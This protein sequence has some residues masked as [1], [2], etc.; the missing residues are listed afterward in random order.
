MTAVLTPLRPAAHELTRLPRGSSAAGLSGHPDFGLAD[1]G[2]LDGALLAQ[3]PVPLGQ[4]LPTA[5]PAFLIVTGWAALQRT[6]ARGATQ[7]LGFFLPGDVVGLDTATAPI[8]GG[9]VV[10]LTAMRIRRLTQGGRAILASTPEL[11]RAIAALNLKHQ[12]RVQD[13][14]VRLGGMTALERTAHLLA[15]LDGRL[16]RG[17]AS[18]R[19]RSARKSCHRPWV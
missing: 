17:A 9:E 12:G 5:D 18:S 10:A 2:T 13:Q 14:I 11:I 4:V 8:G 1:I 7:I 6:T 3:A 19:A 16:K 15:E